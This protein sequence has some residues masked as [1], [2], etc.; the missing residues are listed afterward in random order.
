[1]ASFQVEDK[2][3]KAWFF[4]ETFLLANIDVEVVLGILFL[5][6]SNADIQF[7][8]KELIWRSYTT[9]EALLT[10]KQV[11]FINKKEFAK[12]TLDKNSE[13]L[14]FMWHP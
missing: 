14:L 5:T 11:D 6:F 3:G 4:Q 1:M 8:E 10:T 2:L 7:M 12:V 9:A 13:F